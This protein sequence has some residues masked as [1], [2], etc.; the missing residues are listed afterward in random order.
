MGPGGSRGLQIRRRRGSAGTGGFDSHTLPPSHVL[1]GRRP[2]NPPGGPR[3]DPVTASRGGETSKI[4]QRFE[5]CG[6]ERDR[7]VPLAVRAGYR[8][9]PFSGGRWRPPTPQEV[10]GSIQS[11]QGAAETAARSGSVLKL[12]ELNGIE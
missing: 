9:A 8:R 12:V 10:A 3:F 6:A 1:R 7:T 11:P 4:R 2:P 5:T